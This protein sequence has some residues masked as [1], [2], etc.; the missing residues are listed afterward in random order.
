MGKIKR[1]SFEVEARNEHAVSPHSFR[2]AVA[3]LGVL[4]PAGHKKKSTKT[5]CKKGHA[6]KTIIVKTF[7]YPYEYEKGQRCARCGRKKKTV[8]VTT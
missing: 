5:L 8:L 1:T 6:W 7:V 4:V 3:L 2:N